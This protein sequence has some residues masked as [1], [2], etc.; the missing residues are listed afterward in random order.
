MDDMSKAKIGK[1][2]S[3]IALAVNISLMLL[4]GLTGVAAR[5]TAII[6]DAFNNG[7]D[8]FSTIAVYGGIRIAYLPPDEKHQY[9]HAKAEPIVSKIVAIIIGFTAISIGWNSA[10]QIITG[11]T[12]SPGYL[13]I[14]VSF[15]SIFL[16]YSLYRY[17]NKMGKLIGSSSIVADSYNHRSD[18]LASSAVIVGV[19]GA[20]MG[21]PVLDPIAGLAVSIIIF[22]T[23][24]SIY[25]EAIDALMDTSPGVETM[26]KIKRI[27]LS[28]PG[29]LQIN[30]LKARKHGSGLH[31]DL[32][33]C[34]D[35][36]TT[37]IN[38]H[39]VASSAK[40]QIIK[41]MSDVKDVMVHVNP[42]SPLEN[43]EG[44]FC[45]ECSMY[46]PKS[47]KDNI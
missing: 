19:L 22:K 42:C 1:R 4:K 41:Q 24:I 18:V 13:A 17:T 31:I 30:E 47:N 36:N 7:T 27:T 28:T 5:S 34:V 8:I 46:H 25:I 20:R 43:K 37:V 15:I 9:G 26:N 29:V 11:T 35:G 33:I 40:H 10:K 38:G 23:G 14:V 16:K 45:S 12:E 44:T 3:N 6:A 39:K 32:K 21:Y 2:T